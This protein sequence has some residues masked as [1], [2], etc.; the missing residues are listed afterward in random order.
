[1]VGVSA[2]AVA[3][4]TYGAPE[5][6]VASAGSALALLTGAVLVLRGRRKK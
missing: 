2:L 6:G 1:M 3:S 4:Q 5:I